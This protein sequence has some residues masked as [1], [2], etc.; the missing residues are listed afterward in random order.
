MINQDVVK[1]NGRF[2]TPAHA[3]AMQSI[4]A[5]LNAAQHQDFS[6][7]AEPATAGAPEDE[8][9]YWQKRALSQSQL[10]AL[11][12]IAMMLGEI[13]KTVRQINIQAAAFAL[14]LPR[15][16]LVEGSLYTSRLYRM[17]SEASIAAAK[18]GGVVEMDR[19]RKTKEL[20]KLRALVGANNGIK[21][22]KTA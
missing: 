20:N 4:E 15:L 3:A 8:Q 18:L 1:I 16:N 21:E 22:R 11:E 17:A 12:G 13:S 2:K 9:S 14:P 7:V 10:E 6:A 5:C 19:L